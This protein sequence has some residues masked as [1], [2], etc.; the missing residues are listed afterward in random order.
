[1]RTNSPDRGT[2]ADAAACR[3]CGKPIK[4]EAALCTACGWRR[5]GE[6]LATRVL[7]E[8]AA[9]R[10]A[11][12]AETAAVR[13]GQKGEREA[14]GV[15]RPARWAGPAA[16]ALGLLIAVLLI[17]W[18]LGGASVAP[19]RA[20][21]VFPL[22]EAGGRLLVLHRD[23]AGAAGAGAAVAVELDAEP[24]PAGGGPVELVPEAGGA[25]AA[26]VLWRPAASPVTIDLTPA[27]AAGVRALLPVR[28]PD[29]VFEREADGTPGRTEATAMYEAGGFAGRVRVAVGGGLAPSASGTVAAASEADPALAA[30]LD[31]DAARVEVSA[32]AGAE[33]A[34][35]GAAP[36]APAGGWLFVLPDGAPPAAGRYRVER[37]GR[38]LATIELPE[39]AAPG[40]LPVVGGGTRPGKI[41]P[42]PIKRAQG[43][44][45]PPK[46][47]TNNPLSYFDVL[48]GAG[49][50]ARGLGSANN[51]RQMATGFLLYEQRHGGFPDTLEDLATVLGP[52]DGLLFNQRTGDNPG[53]LYEKPS[54]GG[55]QPMVW[56]TIG[57]QK[58]PTGAVLMSD[59]TIR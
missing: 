31:W 11:L 28:P 12:G 54:G 38:T 52:M 53:F 26:G 59:G 58:D 22:F 3:R 21:R 42:S 29:R 55:P 48:S 4:P 56:E 19:A 13:G 49:A 9:D 50:N 17:V 24:S 5:D 6:T 1:M 32:D 40:P 51:M 18:A 20:V 27:A 37:D 57:G 16:A 46:I 41:L 15:G 25:A 30:S 47:N 7:A 36:A 2:G 34:W 14:P 45:P 44:A 39:A 10:G 33:L 35:A 43:T 8:P 23:E